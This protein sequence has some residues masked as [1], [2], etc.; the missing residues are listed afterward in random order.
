MTNYIM[1]PDITYTI[2]ELTPLANVLT[3]PA[4]IVVGT[5]VL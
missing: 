2:D 1:N 3:D 5:T 4:V